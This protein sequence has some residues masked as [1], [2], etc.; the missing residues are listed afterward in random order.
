MADKFAD[1][2]ETPRLR[3]R[4]ATADDAAFILAIYNDPAFLEFV[5]N[6]DIRTQEDARNYIEKNFISSYRTNGMGLLIVETKDTRTPIGC[7]GLVVRP[8][9]DIPDIGFAYLPDYT[10]KGFGYEAARA[11]LEHA[12]NTLGLT[13]IQA[14]VS[15]ENV[16]S[17]G[18]IE[19][20]GFSFDRDEI[21][22]G[23]HSE[24]K[25]FRLTA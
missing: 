19:K 8:T 21:L 11:T 22:A 17:I 1:T 4:E 24:T 18:L 20:L 9:F 16:K 5:G 13:D 15:P 10:S 23:Q 6:K 3:M 12:R 7:C 2:I 14:L 25:I